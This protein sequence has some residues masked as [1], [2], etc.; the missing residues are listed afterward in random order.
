MVKTEG[1]KRRARE[2]R[3]RTLAQHAAPLQRNGRSLC[4][5]VAKLGRSSAAP[6]LGI[7]KSATG[8]GNFVGVAC[9]TGLAPTRGGIV[10]LRVCGGGGGHPLSCRRRSRR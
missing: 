1:G 4:G 2:S 9:R 6:L 8:R 10:R 7:H 5:R 3:A